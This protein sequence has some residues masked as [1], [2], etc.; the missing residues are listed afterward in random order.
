MFQWF[1]FIYTPGK[2]QTIALLAGCAVGWV[3]CGRQPLVLVLMLLCVGMCAASHVSGSCAPWQPAVLFGGVRL[4][5]SARC[6]LLSC[7]WN[8]KHWGSYS[9]SSSPVMV[10]SM[11]SSITCIPK[12][13]CSDES[14]KWNS[15]LLNA[16]W[17]IRAGNIHDNTPVLICTW[18]LTSRSHWYINKIFIYIDIYI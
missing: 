2:L 7:T 9:Q 18:Q 17:C 12:E 3:I 15:M 14:C 4:W 8:L 5:S 11:R 6:P 16:I 10:G 13:S 1:I